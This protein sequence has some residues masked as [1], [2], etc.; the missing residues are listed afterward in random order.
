MTDVVKPSNNDEIDLFELIKALWDKKWWIILST[1]VCTA[2]A[3]V[4]A[5]TAKEQWTSKAVIIAPKVA[6]MGD[7]L[8]LRSEYANILNIKEFTSKDVVNNLFSN[9]STALFSSNIKREFFAQSKWFQNYVNENA[10][11][12]EAKQKLL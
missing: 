6:D 9:F 10:K 12:E 1:F 7:Y 4:Y 3:G 5:F 2:L 8:S 11:N